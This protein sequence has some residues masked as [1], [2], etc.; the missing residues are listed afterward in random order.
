MNGAW[1]GIK[2]EQKAVLVRQGFYPYP[3]LCDA[4]NN[5]ILRARLSGFAAFY[6]AYP[7]AQSQVTTRSGPQS[8]FSALPADANR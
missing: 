1:Y 5:L 8:S 2:A 7:S 6:P 3:E 4:D